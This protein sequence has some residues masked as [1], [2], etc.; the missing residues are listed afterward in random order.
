ML[1]P[2]SPIIVPGSRPTACASSFGFLA[3]FV[4]SR[5]AKGI[6]DWKNMERSSPQYRAE[7]GGR[8]RQQER[9]KCCWWCVYSFAFP[10][11]VLKNLFASVKGDCD[12]FPLPQ[13]HSFI[14][15]LRIVL[16]D[17]F[18]YEELLLILPFPDSKISLLLAPAFDPPTPT[19]QN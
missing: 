17:F 1:C 11:L 10:K 8:G 12:Y 18:L 6:R 4:S 3:E 13:M 5:A 9:R 15:P 2:H 16:F 7:L 14:L 19:R